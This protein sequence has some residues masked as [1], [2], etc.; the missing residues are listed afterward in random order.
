MTQMHADDE[1]DAKQI[2]CPHKQSCLMKAA[3]AIAA[4][5]ICA[6]HDVSPNATKAEDQPQAS[7]TTSEAQRPS[8]RERWKTV[9]SFVK[10]GKAESEAGLEAALQDEDPNIR[11]FAADQLGEFESVSQSAIRRLIEMLGDAA[12]RDVSISNHVFEQRPI[13]YDCAHALGSI[14]K[15]AGDA[16]DRLREV[17][18]SHSDGETRMVSAWALLKIGAHEAKASRELQD[19]LAND[20]EHVR[21]EA[22]WRMGT[23]PNV[24]LEIRRL[25][26]AA[27][28]NRSEFDSAVLVRASAVRSLAE[29]QVDEF[30]DHILATLIEA[31]ADEDA[32]VREAA[33]DALAATGTKDASALAALHD[34]LVEDRDPFFS[35]DVRFAAVRALAKIEHPEVAIVVLAERLGANETAHIKSEIISSLRHIGGRLTP[36]IPHLRKLANGGDATLAEEAKALLAEIEEPK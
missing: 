30:A 16:S 2:Q 6:L 12:Q 10:G 26:A 22:A 33:A 13:V 17:M 8:L 3:L 4:T 11:A 9:Q 32:I 19:G 15:A 27:L 7:P 23:L 35:S 1:Q 29:I 24:P 5:L 36:A 14:G 20:R 18:E 21:N 31:T 34:L 25:F 28:L